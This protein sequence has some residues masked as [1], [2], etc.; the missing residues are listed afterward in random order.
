MTGE[1][2]E[3]TV[4]ELR[5]QYPHWQIWRGVSNLW[6][7]RLPNSSPPVLVRGEDLLDLRDMIK[8]EIARREWLDELAKP[9]GPAPK[10]IRAPGEVSEPR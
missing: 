8:Q 10:L 1:P 4:E 2:G 9:A 3:P 5:Y 7:A 6:Y